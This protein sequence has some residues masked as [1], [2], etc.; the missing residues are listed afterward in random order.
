MRL[1]ARTGEPVMALASRMARQPRSANP[2]AA[3][4]AASIRFLRLPLVSRASTG[5]KNWPV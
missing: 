4:S 5:A 3:Y 2:V 1:E